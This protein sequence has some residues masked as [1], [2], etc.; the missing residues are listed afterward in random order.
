MCL[1]VIGATRAVNGARRSYRVHAVHEWHARAAAAALFFGSMELNSIQLCIGQ[2]PLTGSPSMSFRAFEVCSGV[3]GAVVF[4][5]NPIG[6]GQL[7]SSTRSSCDACP[8]FICCRFGAY[9]FIPVQGL[10]RRA[11]TGWWGRGAF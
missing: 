9:G 11:R 10:Q 2:T 5:G 4:L 7:A 6:Q 8:F 1:V 3:Y